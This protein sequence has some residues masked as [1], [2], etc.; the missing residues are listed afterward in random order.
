ML[1]PVATGEYEDRN[2]GPTSGTG[3]Y[4][5]PG[6]DLFSHP[7]TRAVSSALKRFTTVFGM[8]TG[9]SAS[10]ESPG[11]ILNGPKYALFFTTWQG[12]IG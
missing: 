9:G 8:G 12:A 1:A 4:K 6:G 5:P 11:S 10:L 2:P 7:V 3:V